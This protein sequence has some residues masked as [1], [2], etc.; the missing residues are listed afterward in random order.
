MHA[1]RA[2]AAARHRYH[3]VIPCQV[4]SHLDYPLVYPDSSIAIVDLLGGESHPA[5][6]RAHTPWLESQPFAMTFHQVIGHFCNLTY[7]RKLPVGILTK[8][9]HCLQHRRFPRVSPLK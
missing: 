3:A 6:N 4:V 2:G 9:D 5:R 7:L 1:T 8:D